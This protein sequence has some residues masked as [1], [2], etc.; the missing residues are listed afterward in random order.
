MPIQLIGQGELAYSLVS[1]DA[2][3]V[4]RPEGGASF[5]DDVVHAVAEQPITDVVLL[6]HGW[7]G[8][9]PDARDQYQR[10][11]TAMAECTAD[12]AA[13][14]E[15]VPE[16]RPLVVGLHWPSKA[17]GDEELSA[18]SFAATSAPT[19]PAVTTVDGLVEQY[20]AQLS[21]TE[22]ARAALRTI[23]EAALADIAP[24]TLP[25][26]VADAYAV[27]DTEIGLGADGEGAEPG[28]DRLPFD[29]S[30]A[31]QSV[32]DEED[33]AAFGGPALGGILAPLRTLT[34][35][36]M[37]RRACRFG[38]TGAADLLRRMQAAVPSGRQVRFHLMGH[39]FGCI[40][41]S[42]CVAGRP[43]DQPAHVDTL[44]LVQGAMSLWS[45]CSSIPSSPRRAG[46]FHRIVA[47][48]LVRGATVATM[49]EHDRAVGFFYP[50][51][52]AVARQR[53]YAPGR[54]PAFG[55]LGTFGARGPLTA[56]EDLRMRDVSEPYQFEPHT[57]YNLE[58]SAV[59]ANGGGPSGA[60]SDICHP[61]VAHAVWSAIGVG[62]TG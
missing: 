59:I 17:W 49:S 40:V 33:L 12:R 8:D 6:S 10:W 32:L 36:Q 4:E 25:P 27:L 46:Y 30:A 39:S 26:E 47:D 45:Y 22:R 21:Q 43:E 61:A 1:Y 50:L 44:I 24:D 18:G 53:S 31:Y 52:A 9:I 7:N 11:L 55:G 19:S 29:A 23:F 5:S 14:V 20:A 2:A 60:H 35:W 62:R 15:R 34:F 56:V 42:A 38:E 57:I 16:F 37:K 54:L 41:V 51:G 13:L 48:G 58:S 28:A 3:G